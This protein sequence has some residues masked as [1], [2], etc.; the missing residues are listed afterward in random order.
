MDAIQN[1][2][3]Y[4]SQE[5]GHLEVEAVLGSS[6]E[7]KTRYQTTLKRDLYRAIEVLRTLQAERSEREE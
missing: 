2:Q 3:N 1:S 5:A 4:N 7:K 6:L